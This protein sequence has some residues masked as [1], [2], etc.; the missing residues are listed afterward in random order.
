[1]DTLLQQLELKFQFTLYKALACSNDDGIVEFV[2]GAK[3][4]QQI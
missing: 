3:T 4:I 2:V 1:M